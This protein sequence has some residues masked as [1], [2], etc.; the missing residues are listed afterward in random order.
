MADFRPVSA[1]LIIKPTIY[2]NR[3]FVLINTMHVAPHPSLQVVQDRSCK[4]KDIYCTTTILS[5]K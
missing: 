2:Q 5:Y 3:G 4:K 1:L